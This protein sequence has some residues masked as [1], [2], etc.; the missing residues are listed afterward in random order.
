MDLDAVLG[1]QVFQALWSM[2]RLRPASRSKFD[3]RALPNDSELL[4]GVGTGLGLP[5][6]GEIGKRIA[7]TAWHIAGHLSLVRE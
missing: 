3:S 6:L 5:I 7:R 1:M 2:G 4:E